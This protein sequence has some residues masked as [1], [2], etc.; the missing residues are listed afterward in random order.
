MSNFHS[1]LSNLMKLV[2]IQVWQHTNLD[3]N[4]II[5]QNCLYFKKKWSESQKKTY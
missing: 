2:R 3:F 1:I 4:K 5:Q